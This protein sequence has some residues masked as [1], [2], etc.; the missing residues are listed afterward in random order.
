[1]NRPEV[2]YVEL[3]LS[4]SFKDYLNKI[5]KEMVV[6]EEY[7]N[8]PVMPH[9]KGNV[10]DKAHLTFFFG[11]NPDMVNN[12]E[13]LDLIKSTDLGEL[14]LGDFMIIEGYQ[15]LYRI[16]AIQV[17]DEDKKLSNFVNKI[18]K[19]SNR[20]NSYEFRPHIT[21]AYVH[22]DFQIPAELP[23]VEPTFRGETLHVT[24]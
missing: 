22:K 15:S 19:F 6:D 11:L 1:M 20:P 21:L 24:I 14:K 16:L 5:T 2:A 4:Q 23:E 3:T 12:Q 7:Y 8:S 9:I 17:I 13:L 18:R 10:T